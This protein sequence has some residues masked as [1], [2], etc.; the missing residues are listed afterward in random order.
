VEKVKPFRAGKRGE[1]EF[2]EELFGGGARHVSF[3]LRARSFDQL[4][5]LDSGGADRHTGHAA[6]AGVEVMYGLRREGD[7]AFVDEL[8]LVDAAAR[9]VHFFAPEGVRGAGGQAEAA[10]DALVD[11]RRGRRMVGI[12]GRML[13]GCRRHRW[14]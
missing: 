6:E 7:L 9:R 1:N 13:V 5:V 12:E 14:L 3:D 11:E 10:V 4:V 2:A 8:H